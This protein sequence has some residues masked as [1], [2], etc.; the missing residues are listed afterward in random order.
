MKTMKQIA[1]SALYVQTACNLSG[2]VKSFADATTVLWAEAQARG[3]G[4][5]W[6]NKHPI[7]VLYAY[8][9]AHLSG[10]SA[11][12]GCEPYHSASVECERLA[13]VQR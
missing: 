4:T 11:D 12:D 9:I 6:V 7:S 5:E 3:E 2:V 10:I 13:E 1:L 8:Q